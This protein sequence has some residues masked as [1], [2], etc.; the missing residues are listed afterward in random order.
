MLTGRRREKRVKPL[1]RTQ[2]HN[3]KIRKDL[4]T[5]NTKIIQQAMK[6]NNNMKV[7]RK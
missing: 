1:P 4:R 7:L 2:Q 6:V 3:K 5:Y